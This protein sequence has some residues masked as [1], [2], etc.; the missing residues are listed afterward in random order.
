MEFLFLIAGLITGAIAMYFYAV[1][2]Q[3]SE[4]EILRNKYIQQADTDKELRIKAEARLEAM[5]NNRSDDSKNLLNTVEAMAAK[6][7]KSN[8]EM[9]ISMAKQVLEK[10]L[11]KAG[12]DLKNNRENLAG[13]IDPLKSSLNKHEQLIKA[14]K[15][16]SN[17]TFGSMKTY[18]TA[19]ASQQQQ[20]EKETSALVSAL[21]APKIRG[22]WGEIGLRRI[23]EFSGMN[24][25]CDFKEQVST[26]TQNG[27]LRP[28]MIVNLPDKKK[29]VVDSKV[30]LNA[31]LE[32]LE[33]DSENKQRELGLKHTRAVEQHLKNLSSKSYW[34]QFNDSIDFVVMYIEVEPAFGM[35]LM[36]NK[37]LLA[38]GINNRV[39]FA[40]P[41]TLI[42]LLQTVAYSWKQHTATENA[43]QIWKTAQEVYDRLQV[44]TGHIQKIGQSIDGLSKTYNQAV[45]SWDNRVM[46]GIRKMENL[47]ISS[48]T[49]D[50]QQLDAVEREI[51]TLRNNI[52]NS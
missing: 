48:E 47:G 29:I 11:V 45:G 31:Y 5:Q 35:A 38:Q 1:W 7:L 49:K 37:N 19:L 51:R 4:N 18:L 15:T 52:D 20:L 24:E 41:T 17:Q 32:A 26:A 8:N 34:A 27:M 28:D 3:S 14:L 44:F 10:Y 6:A 22:R 39:I 2:K 30:P 40:T 43:I 25:Y 12:S 13:I 46:P 9:F 50:K 33:T 23:V 36:N 42:A 21:K 16:E